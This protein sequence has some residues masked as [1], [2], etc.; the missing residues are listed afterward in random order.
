MDPLSIKLRNKSIPLSLDCGIANTFL[1]LESEGSSK[2]GSRM[3]KKQN[4]EW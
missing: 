3:Q 4:Q 1:V 2:L